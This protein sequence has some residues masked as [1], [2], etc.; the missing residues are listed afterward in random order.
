[1]DDLSPLLPLIEPITYQSPQTLFAPFADIAW[2]LLIDGSSCEHHYGTSR[3]SYILIDPFERYLYDKQS[4]DNDPLLLLR[5]RLL[6]Y[7]SDTCNTLP[8]FQGGLAGYL[9]YDLTHK[10]HPVPCSSVNDMDCPL[11]CMGFYDV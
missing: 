2:N 4:M 11:V 9:S 8:P 6:K 10:Y 1:M 5:Q 3:Y 7:A